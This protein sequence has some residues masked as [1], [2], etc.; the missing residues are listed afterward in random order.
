MM[1][2]RLRPGHAT[3]VTET[4]LVAAKLPVMLHGACLKMRHA[5]WGSLARCWRSGVILAHV[6]QAT[7]SEVG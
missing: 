6:S 1:T 7:Y 2:G 4:G 5:G 3:Q